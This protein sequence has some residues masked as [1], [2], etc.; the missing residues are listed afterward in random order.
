MECCILLVCVCV[1]VY[2]DICFYFIRILPNLNHSV[3]D[4]SIMV[5]NS[6]DVHQNRLLESFTSLVGK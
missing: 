1:C 2:I 6:C 3:Y 5:L 4:F